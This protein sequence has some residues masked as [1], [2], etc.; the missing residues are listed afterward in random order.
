[1]PAVWLTAVAWVSLLAAAFVAVGAIVYDVFGR[2][3]R[4]QMGIMEAVWPVTAL[5]FGPLAWLGYRRW[6][7]VNSPKASA[8]PATSP[9]MVKRCRSP[10][11]PR[12]VEAGVS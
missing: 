7:R 1:M 10:A 5:Y 8:S 9:H 3:Y 11:G 6:G 12:D 4:Q 2:G